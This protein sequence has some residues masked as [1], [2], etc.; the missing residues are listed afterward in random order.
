MFSQTG[1]VGFVWV[2]FRDVCRVPRVRRRPWR[3]LVLPSV[4]VVIFVG[5]ICKVNG[6]MRSVCH[7]CWIAVFVGL[8]E[9]HFRGHFGSS[10][11]L[12]TEARGSLAR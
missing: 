7:A 8:L 11:L 5:G 6:D 3:C 4:M 1:A 2:V 12:Q 9:L 10:S